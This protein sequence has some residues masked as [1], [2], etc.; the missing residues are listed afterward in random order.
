MVG[1]TSTNPFFRSPD[2]AVLER[3]RSGDRVALAAL[4]EQ[5]GRAAYNLA[6]RML[7]DYSQAEDVVQDVFVRLCSALGGYR[8][9]APFGAWFR[10]L[11]VNAAIDTLRRR[12]VLDSDEPLESL[13]LPAETAERQVLAWQ[14]LER[15]SPRA[16]MVLVL[17]ELEGM[18]HTDLAAQFGQ[19]ES[20]SKSLLARALKRLR[21]LAPAAGKESTHGRR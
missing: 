21:D 18:T 3:A 7:G 10:R 8:A 16:R 5:F 2:P 12:R 1:P 11:V 20:Y 15:L 9:D 4:Y 19:S 13:S 6:L 14:L 17:H